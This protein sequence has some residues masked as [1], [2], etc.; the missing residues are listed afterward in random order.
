MKTLKPMLTACALLAVVELN[1]AAETQTGFD[2]ANAAF[3]EK[4]FAEAANGYETVISRQGFSA[5]VLFNL[6][7]AYYRAGNLGWA[8]L[9]YE[10]AQ[11]LAPRDA[12]IA[13][14]LSIARSKA[15]VADQPTHLLSSNGLSWFGSA[16]MI[17]LAAGLL[18]RQVTKRAG[19]VWRTWIITNSC[20][21]LAAMLTLFLRNPEWNR[22]IVVAK[23]APAY[24]A[25]V[26]VTQRMFTLTEGQPVSIRKT[27]GDFLLVEAVGGRRGWVTP[28]AVER[29]TPM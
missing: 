4:R 23:S 16:A 11:L 19:F 3:A 9:N 21:L 14:N 7:N 2:Q 29:V 5:S 13:A 25:P 20:V 8:I 1:C 26:T 17:S 12:D 6:A 22:G 15:G 27:S 24:I 10:R 18:F 28:A